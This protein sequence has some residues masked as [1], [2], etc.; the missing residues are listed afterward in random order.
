MDVLSEVLKVVK[1]QGAMFYNGEFSLTA[2]VQRR[3]L[4]GCRRGARDYL[5][6]AHGGARFCPSGRWRAHRSRCGG[7]CDLSPWRR[8]HPRKRP[9]GGGCGHGEGA[10]SNFLPG[11]EAIAP[12]WWRGN[13][14]IRVWL[15]GLRAATKPSFS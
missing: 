3:A 13:Y 15:H 1:L 12:G 4:R 10:S 9:C 6:L 2:I 11:V 5:S 14:E 7:H 8:T